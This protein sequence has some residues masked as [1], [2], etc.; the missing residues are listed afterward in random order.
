MF[1]YLGRGCA[2]ICG[3]AWSGYEVLGARLFGVGAWAGRSEDVYPDAFVKADRRWLS[4]FIDGLNAER[5]LIAAECVGDE[6]W[7]IKAR[8]A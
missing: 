1:H 5:I 8:I 2:R 4:G 3:E 6:R 7:F